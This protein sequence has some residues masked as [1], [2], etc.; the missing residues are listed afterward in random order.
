MTAALGV[1]ASD[2]ACLYVVVT[3]AGPYFR[4]P[5]NDISLLA[6]GDI[7]RSWPGGT[8][9]YKLGVNYAPTFLPHRTAAKKGYDQILWL[10]G[11][12]EKITEV[13][14]MNVFVAVQRDDGGILFSYPTKYR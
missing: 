6:V 14:A 3:P 1:G 11:D 12:D 2:S 5:T 8:G 7:V 13:G 9:S 4:G 10:L